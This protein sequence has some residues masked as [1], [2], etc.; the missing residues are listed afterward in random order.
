MNKHI[1]S[2]NEQGLHT[3]RCQISTPVL[4]RNE[5][6]GW[7]LSNL[8]VSGCLRTP[9]EF[10]H[11]WALQKYFHDNSGVF[12]KVGFVWATSNTSTAV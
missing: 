5:Q 7:Q 1:N 11:R 9:E 4:Y 8:I 12:Q 3:E 2:T 6:H 10:Q